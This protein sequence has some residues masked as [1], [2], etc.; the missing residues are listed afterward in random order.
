MADDVMLE[1][2]HVSKAFP[3]TQALDD[4]SLAVRRGEVHAILGENGAG[5]STLMLILA[6]VHRKD[7]GEITLEGCRIELIDPKHAQRLGVRIVYQELSV[8]P[9]MSVAENIFVNAQPTNRLGLIDIGALNQQ[10]RKALELLDVDLDPAIPVRDLSTGDQQLV[11][12]ARALT[13]KAKVLILDEPTSAL[14]E[15]ETRVLF[16]VIRRIKGEGVA[17]L[18]VS[19]K[20]SE[21]LQISDRLTVLRDGK[22]VGTLDTRE[23]TEDRIVSMMVGRDL[24]LYYPEMGRPSEPCLLE[25]KGLK[26]EKFADVSFK[27]YKGEILGLAGLAGAGRSE[28]ARAIFGADPLLGGEVCL[29]GR[30]TIIRSPR[31]AVRAGLGYLPEDRKEQ[32]LFLQ[33]SVR[34]NMVAANL[35][36]FS[37]RLLMDRGRALAES[38]GMIHRLQVKTPSVEQT[39]MNLS[40]GNQQKVMVAKWLLTQPKVLIVD[41]PTRGVDVGVKLEIHRLLRQLADDG[42]GIIMISSELP[43]VLGMS[44]RIVVMHGGRV[45]GQLAHS[46]ATEE[47]LMMLASGVGSNNNANS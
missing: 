12:I 22:V 9:A 21:I 41:E 31:D 40:G 35:R 47:K 15:R 24:S 6:G 42:V 37:G 14:A 18:Y 19:H 10:A 29:N 34:E 23:A 7:A 38:E 45:A 28:V 33:M 26:G 16:D 3:G 20:L 46:H 4:V 17:I 8:V 43:E 44:D 36:W 39:V 11:E 32:G 27:L 5:K 13:G 1:V 25:V 30:K 2:R